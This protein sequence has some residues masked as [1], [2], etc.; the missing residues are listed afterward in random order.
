VFIVIVCVLDWMNEEIGDEGVIRI[1]DGLETNT[2]LVELD[3]RCVLLP[4]LFFIHS[5]VSHFL[6]HVRVSCL[7]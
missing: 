7:T 6:N 1:A 4:R 5:C 2:S 3:V